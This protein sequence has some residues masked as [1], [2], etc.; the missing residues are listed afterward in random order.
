[1][2]TGLFSTTGSLVCA[3][4]LFLTGC[5]SIVPET[6]GQAEVEL[7]VPRGYL[8]TLEISRGGQI[9]GF[10]PFVG[11]YF[12][13]PEPED[14]TKLRFV[15]FN[16]RGFYSSDAPVNAKLYEGEAVFSSLADVDFPI[17]MKNRINPIFFEDAPEKW[18]ENR[19][20]PQAEFLHFHSCY[21]DAGPVP[22][23]YWLRHRAVR[24]FTYDMGGRVTQESPL[25]HEVSQGPDTRFPR[26]VEFD[27]GPDSGAEG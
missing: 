12:L 2:G 26:I 25:Y 11:Y 4:V 3:A 15:C 7:S 9:L 1:M 17:P 19:P 14:L 6:T 8:D 5:G 10:G 16:E 13:P 20:E 18:I 21:N 23:G 27:R 22:A 24:A